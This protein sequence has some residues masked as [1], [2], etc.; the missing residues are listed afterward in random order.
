MRKWENKFQ[1]SYFFHGKLSVF[2]FVNNRDLFNFAV[3]YL[4][5]LISCQNNSIAD[6]TTASLTAI[7]NQ[8]SQVTS[9][10]YM[11]ITIIL[12]FRRE[13]NVTFVHV[14]QEK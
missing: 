8:A 7:N 10:I 1:C 9:R 11:D 5:N 13:K 12:I 6:L 2:L 14:L 3:E 4:P